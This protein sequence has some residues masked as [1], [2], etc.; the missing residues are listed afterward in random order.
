MDLF[1]SKAHAAAAPAP[2]GAGM[3]MIIMHVTCFWFSVSIL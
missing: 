2:A 3:D 1:I